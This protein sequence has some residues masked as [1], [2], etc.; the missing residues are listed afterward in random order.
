LTLTLSP[1]GA[2][3]MGS[4]LADKAAH[5]LPL[6]LSLKN[7]AEIKADSSEKNNKNGSLW[8]ALQNLR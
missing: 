6:I 5:I 4:I 2:E 8:R 1:I 7:T 3:P